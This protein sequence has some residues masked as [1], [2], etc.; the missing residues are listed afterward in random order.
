MI[1][2]DSNILVYAYSRES[3]WYPSCHSLCQRILRE[4]SPWCL[5]VFCLGEFLRVVTHPR[6]YPETARLDE[7][8]TWLKV[9][10]QAPR[11]NILNPGPDFASLYMET[12]Q[13]ANARG[14]MA[15]DAQIAAL[16]REH[17]VQTLVTY[18]QDFARFPGLRCVAPENLTE[19]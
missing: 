15:F 17:R 19:S 8:L 2:L 5:P 4:K 14:N 10:T 6:L 16:C 9:L 3:A 7:A 13:Q 11:L 18:D 12:I 1:A